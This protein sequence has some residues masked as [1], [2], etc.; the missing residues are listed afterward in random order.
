[1][2]N[3]EWKSRR[4]QADFL[5]VLVALSGAALGACAPSA[6]T[7]AIV[8]VGNTGCPAEELAVFSYKR[9]ERSW[10]AACGDRLYV[11]SD[12]RGATECQLQQAHTEEPELRERARLLSGLPKTARD[13]FVEIDILAL[14]WEEFSKRVQIA[15]KLSPQQLQEI[16]DL[17]TVFAGF[18][19][20][21]N[22]QLRACSGQNGVYQL[23]VKQAGF[24][25]RKHDRCAQNGLLASPEIAHLADGQN[26]NYYLATDV[27]DIQPL[28]RKGPLPP[29]S[30]AEPFPSAERM[31]G[32]GAEAPTTGPAV[33][34]PASASQGGV[35]ASVRSWLDTQ[36]AEV[37]ECVGAERV[38]LLVHVSE[39]GAASVKLRGQLSGSPEE[40]CVVSALGTRQFE[41]GPLDVVHLVKQAAAQQSDPED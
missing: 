21:F 16:E 2:G 17:T 13:H 34:P 1:M 23:R 31:A 11:C 15:A 6:R 36:A 5:G 22:E 24:V 7:V 18:S 19:A 26:K 35:E 32:A 28:P 30:P 10:R 33:M 14:S 40:G 29:H 25:S 12:I 3:G 39:T 27:F 37:L 41:A 8:S 4:S 9:K 38:P 20:G